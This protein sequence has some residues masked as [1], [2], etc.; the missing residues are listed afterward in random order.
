MSSIELD[1]AALTLDSNI[2]IGNG[3]NLERGMLKQLE[4]FAS[5]PVQLILSEI[6]YREIRGHML[7]RVSESRLKLATA[8]KA[9]KA[10]FLVPDERADGATEVLLGKL[11]DEEVVDQRLKEFVSRTGAVVVAATSVD[12]ADLVD[13]YFETDPPFETGRDK[14]AEFPDAIALLSLATWARERGARVLAVS[15]DRGWTAFAEG[16]VHV[17]STQD[18]AK[19]LAHFQPHNAASEIIESLKQLIVAGGKHE[20]TDFVSE[21]VSQATNEAEVDVEYFSAVHAELDVVEV[22]YRK[23]E[24]VRD[25]RGT[26]LVDVVR[27]EEGWLVLRLRLLIAYDVVAWFNMSVWDSIDREY[28]R[29]GGSKATREASVETDVLVSLTADFLHGLEHVK[30]GELTIDLELPVIE[31]G[32]VEPNMH[33]E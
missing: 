19:A 8:L 21:T 29:I 6:V 10:S 11:S 30:V 2:F 16:S 13:L 18:L 26:P 14:K 9:V 25:D 23:H 32:D 4:Q 22:H 5:S 27:V 3:L 12:V 17:D 28:V 31:I 7:E 15:E 1:Y 33:D 24:Y 20:I